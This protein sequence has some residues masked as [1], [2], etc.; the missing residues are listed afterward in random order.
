MRLGKRAAKNG[1]ITSTTSAR[2]RQPNSHA[3]MAPRLHARLAPRRQAW[4]TWLARTTER[5]GSEKSESEDRSRL[6]CIF[7]GILS[8]ENYGRTGA[9]MGARTSSGNRGGGV[10]SLS[11]GHKNGGDGHL[12]APG[13]GL[14]GLVENNRNGVSSSDH[15]ASASTNGHLVHCE[16][17]TRVYCSFS[18]S[19]PACGSNSCSCSCS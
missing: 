10:M 7:S 16:A 17:L 5:A 9:L 2:G 1:V 19:L 11:S 3:Q 12:S 14:G 18:V 15:R 13:V 6:T 4:A 8:L